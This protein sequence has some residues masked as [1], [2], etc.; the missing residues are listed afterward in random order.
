[1]D[2]VVALAEG[3]VEQSGERLV[4]LRP[5]QPIEPAQAFVALLNKPNLL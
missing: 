1:V 3:Q 4:E 5:A 2:S